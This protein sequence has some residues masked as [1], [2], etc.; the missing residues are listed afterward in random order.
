[1]I[2]KEFS[3]RSK[4]NSISKY[5]IIHFVQM[6]W[7]YKARVL[8]KKKNNYYYQNTR[9][10]TRKKFCPRLLPS[11]RLS[12]VG[13]QLGIGNK[14]NVLLQAC[15]LG[16]KRRADIQA[17]GEKSVGVVRWD[18]LWIVQCN[19]ADGFWGP[20]SQWIISRDLFFQL[21]SPWIISPR[22]GLSS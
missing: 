11:S 21:S 2:Y 10:L 9:T 12:E 3:K 15:R 1:M 17:H 22:P 18:I 8:I 16:K 19:D 13:Y 7:W 6:R 14:N 5:R 20:S 4:T